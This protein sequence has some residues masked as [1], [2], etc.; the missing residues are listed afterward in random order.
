MYSVEYI[1]N[2]STYKSYYYDKPTREDKEQT[3]DL[4]Q[5]I[6]GDNVIY[7]GS[8]VEEPNYHIS[9]DVFAFEQDTSNWPISASWSDV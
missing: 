3:C 1:I 8:M 6:E 2:G 4:I 9:P 7:I 5:S